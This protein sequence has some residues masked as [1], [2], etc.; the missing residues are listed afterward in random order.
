M[1]L[2]PFLADGVPTRKGGLFRVNMICGERKLRKN[3]VQALRSVAC[4]LGGAAT[5][6][7]GRAQITTNLSEGGWNAFSH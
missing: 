5:L 6:G 7:D 4:V 1:L 3:T 2:D